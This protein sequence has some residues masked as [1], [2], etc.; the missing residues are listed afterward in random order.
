MSVDPL[1]HEF[2]GWNPYHYVHNNPILL[3]DPTGMKADS[4]RIYNTNGQYQFTINDNMPNEDHFMT[5]NNINDLNSQC[6]SDANQEGE[7]A[8]SISKFY[9]GSDTRSQLQSITSL[10]NRLSKEQGFVLTIGS[11]R[12]L[13][14]TNI[15]N[16]ADVSGSQ[17]QDMNFAIE[18]S[19]IKGIVGVGHTHP[20]S[21]NESPAPFPSP[22][23]VFGR[24][25]SDY[26]P[27][28]Y[29]PTN[30]S[31]YGGYLSIVSARNGF[32]IY[33]NAAVPN[34]WTFTPAKFSQNKPILQSFKGK[35]F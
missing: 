29:N 15:S 28:M 14:V 12:Q 32:T 19:G 6:C 2:P 25:L 4:T 13:D 3:T 34:S 22:A 33:T 23:Y 26:S 16:F 5:Q 17:V 21:K 18:K 30:S 9:I 10:S 35:R 1:A 27:H 31:V 7:Y 20:N 24:R 11:D 8:R